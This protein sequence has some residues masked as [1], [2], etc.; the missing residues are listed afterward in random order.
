MAEREK[1]TKKRSQY[2]DYI[3]PESEVEMQEFERGPEYSR[4]GV[5]VVGKTGTGKSTL[6]NNIFAEDV[7]KEGHSLKSETKRIVKHKGQVRGSGVIVYDTQ[8]LENTESAGDGEILEEIK[9][10]I[11]SHQ[12]HLTVFC[13]SMTTTRFDQKRTLEEFNKIGLKW[14]DTIIVLTFADKFHEPPE[15]KMRKEEYFRKKVEEWRKEIQDHLKKDVG[16]PPE[17]ADRIAV[18][19]AT[20]RYNVSLPSNEDWFRPLWLAI[21]KALPNSI[22][23]PFFRMHQEN[24]VIE[25]EEQD[26]GLQEGEDQRP[27][28]QQEAENQPH[29]RPRINVNQQTLL[30]IIKEKF[31]EA[32]KQVWRWIQRHIL[33]SETNNPEE[34]QLDLNV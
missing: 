16:L 19:P 15:L 18:Y 22:V 26:V 4:L 8:G 24:L 11:D 27:Q 14:E 20:Y 25:Q 10:L 5:L 2:C 12:I 33:G 1:E 30:E 29:N 31:G 3:H 23:L 28:D 7:A 13:I 9:G 6:I 17:V 32:W 34:E 21:V